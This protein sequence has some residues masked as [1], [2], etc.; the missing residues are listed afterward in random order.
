MT[1]DDDGGD[2]LSTSSAP[3][4]TSCSG[5][6]R[7]GNGAELALFERRDPHRAVEL[8]CLP[9]VCWTSEA[10]AAA[11]SLEPILAILYVNSHGLAG[12][13]SSDTAVIYLI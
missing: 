6:Y 7:G 1:D 8:S 9:K 4:S 3:P 11:G 12:W 5:C 13:P 10:G 2:G